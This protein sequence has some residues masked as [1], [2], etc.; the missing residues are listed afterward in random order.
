VEGQRARRREVIASG[1]GG[2]RGRVRN[3]P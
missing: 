3:Q 1:S 2:R